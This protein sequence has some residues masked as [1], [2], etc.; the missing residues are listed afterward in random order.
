MEQLAPLWQP[1]EQECISAILGSLIEDGVL[2]TRQKLGWPGTFLFDNGFSTNVG[3]DFELL[4]RL[5]DVMRM[6]GDFLPFFW[7]VE[8]SSWGCIPLDDR[9]GAGATVLCEAL[10]DIPLRWTENGTLLLADVMTPRVVNYVRANRARLVRVITLL[11]PSIAY[12]GPA[13][14]LRRD[15]YKALVCRD[16]L[17]L[18]APQNRWNMIYGTRML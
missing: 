1:N 12:A 3:I 4:G 2:A 16:T 6:L 5:P 9:L 14:G 11:G 17:E 7:L 13:W 18:I 10:K 15:Q 8:Q